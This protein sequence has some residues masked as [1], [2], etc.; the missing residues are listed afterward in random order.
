MM[1][2]EDDPERRPGRRP[3]YTKED[4][5]AAEPRPSWY[6][7]FTKWCANFTGLTGFHTIEVVEL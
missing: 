4:W 2:A 1:T 5:D 3:A 7:Y 6:R